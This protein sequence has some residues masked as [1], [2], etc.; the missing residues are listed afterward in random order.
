MHI[1]IFT[2]HG[3]KCKILRTFFRLKQEQVIHNCNN[4]HLKFQKQWH[5]LGIDVLYVRKQ[6]KKS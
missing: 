4:T 5:S 3:K 2:S 1:Y 6:Q